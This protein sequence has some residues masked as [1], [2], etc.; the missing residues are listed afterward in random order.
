VDRRL[1]ADSVEARVLLIDAAVHD[2]QSAVGFRPFHGLLV[3][4][5]LLQPQVWDLK[6]YDVFDDF[7]DEFR[8]PEHIDQ[9]YFPFGRKG[10]IQVG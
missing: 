8:G 10:L 9:I 4:N 7:G 1:L 2:H 6:T 5:S 3:A